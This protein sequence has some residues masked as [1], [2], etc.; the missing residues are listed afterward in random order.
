MSWGIDFYGGSDSLLAMKLTKRIFNGGMI[1]L[2]V[3][4][5]QEEIEGQANRFYNMGAWSPQNIGEMDISGPSFT[6]VMDL[7]RMMEK[8]AHWHLIVMPQNVANS[9]KKMAGGA[10]SWA[11]QLAKTEID[12]IPIAEV[13]NK[14]IDVNFIPFAEKTVG[15]FSCNQKVVSEE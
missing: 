11:K 13:Y 5:T 15:R 12:S 8:L 2:T 4:G 6:M 10:M 7:G 14:Q 3:D 9:F 1:A